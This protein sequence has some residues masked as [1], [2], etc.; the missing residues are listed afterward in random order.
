MQEERVPR[1]LQ[2][3]AKAEDEIELVEVYFKTIDQTTTDGL[4]YSQSR[5]QHSRRIG[6]SDRYKRW[7]P[8]SLPYPHTHTTRLK[9]GESHVSSFISF[10]NNSPFLAVRRQES[11]KDRWTLRVKSQDTCVDRI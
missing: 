8:F 6:N 5:K 11:L 7:Y 4:L 10:A 9:F 2:G 3:L 1:Q